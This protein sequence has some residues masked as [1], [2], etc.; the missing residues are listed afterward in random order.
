MT[1]IPVDWHAGRVVCVLCVVWAFQQIGLKMTAPDMTPLVQIAL[2]SALAAVLVL[3]VMQWRRSCPPMNKTLWRDGLIVG[4]LFSMEFSSLAQGLRDTSAG[5]MVVLLYTA[6]IFAALWLHWRLPEERLGKQQ[7]VG[8]LLAFSGL[9]LAFSDSVRHTDTPTLRGDCL[10][11]LAGFSWGTLTAWVRCCRLSNA[12]AELTLLFQLACGSLI[13]LAL[14]GVN[15]ELS[16]A[17]FTSWAWGNLLYQGVIVS[18]I[19]YLIWFGLLRRYHVSQLGVFS[20][21][22]PLLG[23]LLG[24]LILDEPLKPVFVVGGV[25]VLSGVGVVMRGRI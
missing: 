1:R 8:I 20:L 6:P 22:T 7:W 24:V 18:F 10:G 25:L 15:G 2:R 14:V 21:L 11:L 12:P 17:H 4:L 23:V 16:T 5:R 19:S 9:A 13:L 3:G